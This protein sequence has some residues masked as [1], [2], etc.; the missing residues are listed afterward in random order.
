MNTAGVNSVDY[1]N[2]ISEERSEVV[3]KNG[4]V[5]KGQWVGQQKHGY[6]V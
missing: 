5:Y 1:T 4:A 3:F 6:G 2:Q